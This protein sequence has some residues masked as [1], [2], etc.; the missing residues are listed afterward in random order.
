MN[1]IPRKIKKKIP[2]GMYCYTAL[3]WIPEELKLI[4]RSCPFYM[5]IRAKE[6][7][8]Q[9]MDEFDLEMP[10]RV[11]GWCRLKT[12]TEVEDQCKNCGEKYDFHFEKN[13]RK[14]KNK[15]KTW[16]SK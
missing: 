5:I 4:T 14:Y 6:K 3:K 16:K 12:P 13:Q 2:L 15:I 11:L 8:K 7:P 1:R 9:L 10:D